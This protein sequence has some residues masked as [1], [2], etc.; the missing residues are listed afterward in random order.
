M[1][2]Q[3]KRMLIGSGLA[4]VMLLC[5]A[6]LAFAATQTEAAAA[7]DIA[8]LRVRLRELLESLEDENSLSSGEL[9][10]L[11][12][13]LREI[14]RDLRS[15]ERGLGGGGGRPDLPSGSWEPFQARIDVVPRNAVFKGWQSGNS[16]VIRIG[17]NEDIY[18]TVTNGSYTAE[19]ALEDVFQGA[20]KTKATADSGGWVIL[21]V[22]DSRG[23]REFRIEQG[24]LGPVYARTVGG[25]STSPVDPDDDYTGTVPS[26]KWDSAYNSLV[27]SGRLKA[28]ASMEWMREQV[29]DRDYA[30][31]ALRD[32][33]E[34][35]RQIEGEAAH[36]RL[37]VLRWFSGQREKKLDIPDPRTD[38]EA[39][40]LVMNN[41]YALDSANDWY[42]IDMD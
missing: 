5:L 31:D 1:E 41:V 12:G 4:L 34:Y 13:E 37:G 19:T 32:L 21:E 24:G 20:V 14:Q 23:T 40:V 6:P 22:A 8:S 2:K 15:I 36:R 33:G 17:A 30:S 35:L 26:G 28:S 9:D 3:L 38:P 25:K 42:R 10:E 29:R 39:F 11:R 27:Q 7:R 18:L 16:M